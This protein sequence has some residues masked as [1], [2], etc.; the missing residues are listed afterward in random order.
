MT[1]LR[2]TTQYSLAIALLIANMAI[3]GME[4]EHHIAVRNKL[5]EIMARPF[6][7]HQA[8][9]Q[10]KL[11]LTTEIGYGDAECIQSI[12]NKLV[13]VN[14]HSPLVTVQLIYPVVKFPLDQIAAEK[15]EILELVRNK[16]SEEDREFVQKEVERFNARAQQM[17]QSAQE[18]KEYVT[19]CIQKTPLMPVEHLLANKNEQ[20][21]INTIPFTFAEHQKLEPLLANFEEQPKILFFTL[22]QATADKL[23][24]SSSNREMP[25]FNALRHEV[26]AKI[27]QEFEP[28]KMALRNNGIIARRAHQED[29]LQDYSNFT[30][31]NSTIISHTSNYHNHGPN[32]HS[33]EKLKETIKKNKLAAQR[34][35]GFINDILARPFEHNT[36]QAHIK[37]TPDTE[38]GYGDTECIKSINDAGITANPH[39]PLVTI[40]LAYPQNIITTAQEQIT[41]EKIEVAQ[42]FSTKDKETN[43][44]AIQAGMARHSQRIN[45]LRQSAQDYQQHITSHAQKMP[46]MPVEHL[47]SDRPV[48]I[49]SIPM[50]FTEQKKLKTLLE[51]FEKHP[52]TLFFTLTQTTADKLNFAANNRE[53]PEYNELKREANELIEQEIELPKIVL[54]TDEIIIRRANQ[55]DDVMDYS[56]RTL[57]NSNL[58]RFE[59]N[60]HNHGPNGHSSKKLK[61]SMEEQDRAIL[62]SKL[63]ERHT[64]NFLNERGANCKRPKL[65]EKENVSEYGIIV[66]N[67]DYNASDNNMQIVRQGNYPSPHLLYPGKR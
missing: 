27:N 49:N 2:K 20:I 4:P 28:K 1:N 37:L 16:C 17:Q 32:G 26:D 7:H 64:V 24:M 10:V 19:S 30:L 54:R 21:I 60:Y 40:E 56:N 51:L 43:K 29:D 35:L 36:C 44:T 13:P 46:L 62:K 14:Q 50:A 52:K 23:N 66:T 18:Y 3:I 48:V 25:I 57:N 22:E 15:K 12:K 31:N 55:E 8:I 9:G 11:P 47:L 65:P 41:N 58:L 61:Q 6:K 42:L 5:N 39:S 33:N 38:I 45:H 34:S 63:G 53:L 59:C 67:T